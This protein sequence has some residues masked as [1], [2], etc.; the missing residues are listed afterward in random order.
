[1]AT[2]ALAAALLLSGA[3]PRPGTGACNGLAL[4]VHATTQVIARS[5]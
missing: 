4:S 5:R 3:G 2:T 1:M